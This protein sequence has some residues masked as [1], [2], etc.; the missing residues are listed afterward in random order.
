MILCFARRHL[1][2]LQEESVLTRGL[3]SSC[4]FKAGRKKLSLCAIT[5]PVRLCMA[6]STTDL[7]GLEVHDLLDFNVYLPPVSFSWDRWSDV[8]PL[9]LLADSGELRT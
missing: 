3:C 1:R 9:Q 8:K 7:E 4:N 2:P 6:L 5:V